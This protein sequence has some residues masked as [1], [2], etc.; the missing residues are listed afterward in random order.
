[1]L[2]RIDANVRP[3]GPSDGAGTGA[4][5]G[6]GRQVALQKALQGLV[7]QNVPAQVQSK[8]SDGNMARACFR[9]CRRR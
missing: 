3:V 7:G 9:R 8:F 5:V 1:M 6:D 2:P 4:P